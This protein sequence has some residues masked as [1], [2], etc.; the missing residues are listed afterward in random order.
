MNSEA[1]L[2]LRTILSVGR[3]QIVARRRLEGRRVADAEGCPAA[4]VVG[5]AHRRQVLMGGAAVGRRLRGRAV[6]GVA[7]G[8]LVRGDGCNEMQRET[9][10]QNGTDAD[11][12]GT[13]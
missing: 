7:S 4:H 1:P 3:W 10:S 9:L 11:A 5:A 12:D 2:P 6:A 13:G 8:D